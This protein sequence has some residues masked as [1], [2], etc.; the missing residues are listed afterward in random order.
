MG[1]H[2]YNGAARNGHRTVVRLLL[3]KDGVKPE[4]EDNTGRTALAWAMKY[5]HVDIV[6]ILR[7][8]IASKR[9]PTLE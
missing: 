7:D 9:V 6:R 2:H 1:G 5:W 3:S 8:H 4:L